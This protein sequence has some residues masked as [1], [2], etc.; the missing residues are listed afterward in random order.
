MV[1]FLFWLE[2]EKLPRIKVSE[3]HQNRILSGLYQAMCSG[4][5]V[6]KMIQQ[7]ECKNSGQ[8]EPTMIN[9]HEY[10]DSGHYVPEVKQ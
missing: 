6:P 10:K 1:A 8:H 9:K 4:Q 2:V 5:H 3:H 7:I